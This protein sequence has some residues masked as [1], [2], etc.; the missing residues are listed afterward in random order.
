MDRPPHDDAPDP[1]L[2]F[3]LRSVTWGYRHIIEQAIED[4]FRRGALGPGREETTRTFFGMLRCADGLHFD[5]VLK[6]F[7]L[8]LNPRTLWILD[9]PGTFADVTQLG[10]DFAEARVYFGR[11]YFQ[12]LGRG[13]FGDSPAQLRRLITELRSLRQ[14]DDELAIAFLKS[15][16]RL[17]DRLSPDEITAYLAE[18]RR[19]F[20]GNRVT[21]LRFME[22]MLKSS[23]QTLERLTR[24]CRFDHVAHALQRLIK[25]LSGRRVNVCELA[26]LDADYLLVRRPGLVCSFDSVYV[27]NRIREFADRSHNRAWYRLLGVVA[28]ATFCEDTFAPLHGRPGFTSCEALVGPETLHLNLFQ[29]IEFLRTVRRLR[30]RWP[31]ARRLIEFGIDV[32]RRA[33]EPSPARAMLLDLLEGNAPTPLAGRILELA[34]RCRSARQTAEAVRALQP[35]PLLDDCPGLGRV[36]LGTL[37]FLPDPLFPLEPSPPPAESLV[38]DLATP[39]QPRPR[40][41][42]AQPSGN[43]ATR[44]GSDQAQPDESPDQPIDAVPA[45]FVYDEWSQPENDY[46]RDYCCVREHRPHAASPRG[47]D[48]N[49]AA[50]AARV[51]RVF[52]LIKPQLA[53]REKYLADGDLIDHDRLLGYLVQRRREPAP[54][55]DFFQRLAVNRRDLA[56][57]ILLD[58]SGST[59]KQAGAQRVIEIEQQAA[60]I[61]GQGLDGLGDRFAVCGFSGSG[62]ENCEFFIY[63]EFEQPWN[64]DARRRV[65]AARPLSSTRIGAAL[66]HAG[67]RLARVDARQRLILL[68]TD[69]QPT[70]QGYDPTTRYAQ[71][72]VRMACEENRRN[73]IHTFCVSA[74]E[75]SRA[76]MAIMFPAQRFAILS[77]I[78]QLPHLLPRAYLRMTT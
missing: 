11:T 63:K 33:Q 3:S 26:D 21:G 50:E 41:R 53:Q 55:V 28:A 35:G 59:S 1:Y 32:Q 56:V 17:I 14:V 15:Y 12:T 24:E 70:D 76:D 54:K 43:P 10:R 61:L 47:L 23:E 25:A 37:L 74:E 9:L 72:D 73:G 57:L 36:P 16:R 75:N 4:L 5:E 45:C 18:A 48:E 30:Q 34:D 64:P 67:Y 42:D 60:V 7:V 13:G 19:V 38:A 52:E 66:R 58:V 22:G 8:A 6:E 39:R 2:G 44:T 77:D 68:I 65:L 29:I 40:D 71:H 69:G 46:Y 51:R 78:R 31:G 20:F 49:A 62:R 27:P